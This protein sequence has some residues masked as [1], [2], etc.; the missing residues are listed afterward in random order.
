MTLGLADRQ[1]SLLDGVNRN[2]ERALPKN[3][4]FA[5]LHRERD[6]LFPDGCSPT[7]SLIA[8]RSVPPSVV[9]AVMVF[10]R[11]HGLPDREAVEAYALDARWRYARPGLVVTTTA[12]GRVSRTR[13]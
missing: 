12:V 3:S 11:L 9:A 5:A 2:C 1:G 4:S 6:G 8:G 7:C 13:C 10:Q